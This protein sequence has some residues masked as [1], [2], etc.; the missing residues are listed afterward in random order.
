MMVLS[1]AVGSVRRALLISDCFDECCI[2]I[3]LIKAVLETVSTT[4]TLSEL[5]LEITVLAVWILAAVS[6]PNWVVPFVLKVKFG[7]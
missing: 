2:T 7:H 3:L 4:I 1:R 5:K 6:V